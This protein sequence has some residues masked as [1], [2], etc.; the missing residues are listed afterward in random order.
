[1][2]NCLSCW[3]GIGVEQTHSI[4]KCSYTTMS[5]SCGWEFVVERATPRSLGEALRLGASELIGSGVVPFHI[6][7]RLPAVV[8]HEVNL[9]AF[10]AGDPDKHS[11]MVE[12]FHLLGNRLEAWPE[13]SALAQE[14]IVRIDEQQ[15]GC[16]GGCV[17]QLQPSFEP[18]AG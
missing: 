7:A 3:L 14:V 11:Q 1:M 17:G 15:C 18:P 13:L 5:P 6:V 12:R 10:V 2:S 8:G 16:R 9:D 4:P